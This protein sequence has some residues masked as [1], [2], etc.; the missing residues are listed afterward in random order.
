MPS[1]RG[2]TAV[3]VSG[4]SI[5]AAAAIAV[6]NLLDTNG[7]SPATTKLRG[8]VEDAIPAWIPARGPSYGEVSATTCML[9]AMP[10][11]GTSSAWSGRTTSTS[12]EQINFRVSATRARTSLPP[13]WVR[14]FDW[15]VWANRV[16]RPPPRTMPVRVARPLFLAFVVLAGMLG[17]PLGGVF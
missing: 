10:R 14:S 9:R 17:G 15:F 3:G 6:T 1:D 2:T 4:P 7:W 5:T 12:S 8:V 11:S 13:R 16:E